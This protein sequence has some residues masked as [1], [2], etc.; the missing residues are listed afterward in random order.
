MSDDPAHLL[1]RRAYRRKS[2]FCL[3]LEYVDGLLFDNPWNGFRWAEV[4]PDLALLVTPEWS[5]GLA[6]GH[7]VLAGALRSTG[8]Y[9]EAELSYCTAHKIASSS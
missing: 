4:A 2:F 7:A 6:M 1:R 9:S 5:E 3:Y 8:R